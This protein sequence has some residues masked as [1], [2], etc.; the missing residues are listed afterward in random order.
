M[1]RKKGCIMDSRLRGND[2]RNAGIK[3]SK[4]KIENR[5]T[6]FDFLLISF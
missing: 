4:Q 6:I 1:K 3:F 5:G 2:G